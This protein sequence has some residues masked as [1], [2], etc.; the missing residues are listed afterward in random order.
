MQVAEKD[1]FEFL[2]VPKSADVM[3]TAGLTE[4]FFNSVYIKVQFILD[5][6]P[7]FVSTQPVY[8][9]L[10]TVTQIHIN[11]ISMFLPFYIFSNT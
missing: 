3:T 5:C 8:S 11:Y 1:N 2:N 6:P 7:V 9:A 10:L 4:F